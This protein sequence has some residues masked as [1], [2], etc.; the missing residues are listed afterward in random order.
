[1][2]EEVIKKTIKIFVVVFAV[3]LKQWLEAKWRT[4]RPS[5]KETRRQAAQ[6]GYLPS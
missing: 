1:M 4:L 6:S 3:N 5:R 2:E